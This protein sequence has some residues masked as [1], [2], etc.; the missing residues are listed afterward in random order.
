MGFHMNVGLMMRIEFNVQ[1]GNG[2]NVDGM[3]PLDL[4]MLMM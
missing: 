3:V 2:Y 4:R 1:D